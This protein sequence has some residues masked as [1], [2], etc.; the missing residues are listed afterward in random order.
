MI[1]VQRIEP[2]KQQAGGAFGG[3]GPMRGGRR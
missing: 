3:L 2:V 1:V